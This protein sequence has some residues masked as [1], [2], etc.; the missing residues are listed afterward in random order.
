MRVERI[1]YTKLV[2]NVGNEPGIFH[3][4]RRVI[5][6]MNKKF[7]AQ[8]RRSVVGIKNGPGSIIENDFDKFLVTSKGK[9]LH[10]KGPGLHNTA[11]GK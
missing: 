8:G 9:Y 6:N 11:K 10:I 4:A 5:R 3:R 1:E 7:K 2:A